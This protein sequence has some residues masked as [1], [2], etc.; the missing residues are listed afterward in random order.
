MTRAQIKLLDFIK[1]NNRIPNTDEA[2]DIC[3]S[4]SLKND[5]RCLLTVNGPKV[6]EYRYWELKSKATSWLKSSIGSLVLQG[7]LNINIGVDV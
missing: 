4:H 6:L 3:T 5:S 7:E 2:V 1:S